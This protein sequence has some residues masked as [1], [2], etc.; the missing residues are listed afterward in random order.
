M[1]SLT[2]F[3]DISLVVDTCLTGASLAGLCLGQVI[4]TQEGESLLRHPSS[5][6]PP[7]GRPVDSWGD[8][9]PSGTNKSAS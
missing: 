7:Q 3:K 9:N 4:H 8:A 2:P 6:P 1:Q 5:P